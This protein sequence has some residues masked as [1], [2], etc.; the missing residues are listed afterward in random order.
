MTRRGKENPDRGVT[1]GRGPLAVRSRC[2]A[3]RIEE[4][5]RP[6]E[7]EEI[8]GGCVKGDPESILGSFVLT[9]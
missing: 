6:G 3:T 8:G 9:E 2:F 7:G 5:L 1:V 4:K